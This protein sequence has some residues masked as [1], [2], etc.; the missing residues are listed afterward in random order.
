MAGSSAAS[1]GAIRAAGS[2][3]RQ[4]LADLADAFLVGKAVV[5]FFAELRE[6]GQS[7]SR[8]HQAYRTLKTFTRWLQAAGALRGNPLAGVSIRTPNTLPQV[9]TDDELRPVLE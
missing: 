3:G 5:R 2:S 9:P 1:S 6:R 4:T 8:V 7:A